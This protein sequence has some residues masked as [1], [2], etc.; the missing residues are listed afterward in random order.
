M[1]ALT[2]VAVLA[3]RTTPNLRLRRALRLVEAA[4]AAALISAGMPETEVLLP[5]LVVPSFAAGFGLGTIDATAVTLTSA[6]MFVGVRA[7]EGG[8]WDSL[9]M[10][11]VIQWLGVAMTAGLMSGWA[12][13]LLQ[14]ERRTT[15]SYAS[16][17]QLL[18]AL[19][20]VSRGLPSGLDEV[21][22]AQSILMSVSTHLE[23]DRGAVYSRDQKGIITPLAYQGADRLEWNPRSGDRVWDSRFDMTTPSQ[24]EQTITPGIEGYCAFLPIHLADRI[25]GLVAVERTSG[26]WPHRNLLAAQSVV[27]DAGLQ[28]ET[29]QLFSE[30]RSIATVEERRRLAREIHD[31]IAQELASLG[32]VVDDLSARSADPEITEE[33]ADLRGELTRMVSELRLSIF[34]LRSDVQPSTGLGAAL[35][36]YV[37]S[38]GAG[39][40][41]TM[42]LILDESSMRLPVEVETEVLRIAQ[43]AITNARKHSRARN[44]WVTCRVDPP[45]VFLRV[46]DDGQGLG[47]PRADSY[48]LEIMR[49]RADRIGADLSMRQR[50]GGGT[51]VELTHGSPTVVITSQVDPR[52]PST[53]IRRSSSV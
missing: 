46:A 31:G 34:D 41:L 29:G 24:L 48:G 37:R 3:S 7:V 6:V 11:E 43:E 53:E 28:L 16:A 51:V 50:V 33:L 8:T 38:T 19:R 49:E 32:Y 40:A 10:V 23:F 39:S 47:S 21:S 17:H 1:I 4:F 26:P 42:H 12:R 9:D 27:D 52:S 18:T 5:Y 30:V 22:L 14:E 13:R 15:S 44:L 20:D 36:S 2:V 35:S 25:I 45:R